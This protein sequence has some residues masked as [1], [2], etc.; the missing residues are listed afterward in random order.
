[1]EVQDVIMKPFISQDA[2][3]LN[4]AKQAATNI[5]FD[6]QD[7]LIDL[8][9]PPEL[10]NNPDQFVPSQLF[11]CLLERTAKSYHC[12][13]FALHVARNLQNPSLGLPTRLMALS[14][15]LRDALNRAGQYGAFYRDT[16]HW[17]HQI[18]EQKVSFAK[19]ASSFSSEH[20]PQRNLLGTAQ[21]Y[22]VITQLAN[23]AWR[24]SLVSF[25]ISDPGAR[26]RDTF[27]EFFQC[28]I[29][30]DQSKDGLEFDLEYLDAPIAS[31]NPE[32]LRGVEMHIES[33]QAELNQGGDVLSRARLIINQRLN[34]GNCTLE[35]L[36]NF[37]QL[38]PS[39]LIES[40]D[41]AET[42]FAQLMEQQIA[43][44]A[45]YYLTQ[46]HAPTELVLQAM[47]PN[48]QPHLSDLLMARLDGGHQW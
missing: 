46:F 17:Q 6:L 30:F 37:L 26:F 39:Q 27:D 36:A 22:L 48:D 10:L 28:P 1:M 43:E 7:A 31:A 2:D 18:G 16:S 8:G 45:T 3:L 21:M 9:L 33:L 38:S 35:A 5:G 34:F 42:N 11:N 23:Y 44:K 20:C 25:S 19:T 29:K 41:Q 15:N 32:L 4:A 12:K 14:A 13:D 40:L 47:M 24:P